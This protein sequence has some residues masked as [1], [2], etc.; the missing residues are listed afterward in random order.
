MDSHK[1]GEFIQTLRKE[2][3]WTQAELAQRLH[4]TDKAVSKWERGSGFPDIKLIEPMADTLGVS[5][6]EIMKSERIDESAIV[7]AN[8]NETIS[9]VIDI[10]ILQKRIEK[11]NLAIGI[12]GTALLV[13]FVFLL[14]T[15]QII[16]FILVY[17]PILAMAVIIV[18]GIMGIYKRRMGTGMKICLGI[19]IGI[20]LLDIM[21]LLTA[22][23]TPT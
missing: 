19:A 13:A 18:L 2:R 1:F 16:G 12:M 6:L 14:D 8:V 23:P 5:I 3:G 15:M 17:L 7:A 9:D 4:V 20:V 10:A 11:R 21:F 22:F